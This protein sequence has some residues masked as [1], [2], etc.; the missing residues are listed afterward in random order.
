MSTLNSS[1]ANRL[2]EE[3]AAQ[4]RIS[5]LE[6]EIIRLRDCNTEL[7]ERAASAEAEEK[8]AIAWRAWAVDQFKPGV[9]P[10]Q[11]WRVS[12][13]PAQPSVTYMGGP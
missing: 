7:A 2:F 13:G 12:G 4:T 1:L 3:K 9:T 10:E 6:K 5:E 11:G 8:M